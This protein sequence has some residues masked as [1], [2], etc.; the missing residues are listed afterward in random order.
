MDLA[1]TPQ[2]RAFVCVASPRLPSAHILFALRFARQTRFKSCSPHTKIKKAT[3]VAFYILVGQTGL[4][5]VTAR[6]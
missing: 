1:T 6:L 3:E 5:P 4:E 2:A